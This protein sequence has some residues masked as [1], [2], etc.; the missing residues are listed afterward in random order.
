MR[1]FTSLAFGFLFG[2]VVYAIFYLGAAVGV[3]RP[4]S[5]FFAAVFQIG[6]LCFLCQ[7]IGY[8]AENTGV[9]E[10]TFAWF[11]KSYEERKVERL[12]RELKKLKQED[13]ERLNRLLKD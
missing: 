7:I 5:S 12:S 2:P 6:V 13:V 10:K 1:V 9:G 11:N 8:F 4:F 3:A